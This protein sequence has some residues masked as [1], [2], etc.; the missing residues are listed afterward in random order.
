MNKSANELR[1]MFFEVKEKNGKIITESLLHTDY[2][3][4]LPK[5]IHLA[6][7]LSHFLRKQDEEFSTITD[8]SNSKEILKK[9]QDKI[10]ES[11][12]LFDGKKFLNFVE[13]DYD[14]E[15]LIHRERFLKGENLDMNVS[16]PFI[17]N[18][19]SKLNR[20]IEEHKSLHEDL[21]DIDA[22]DCAEKFLEYLKKFKPLERNLYPEIFFNDIAYSIFV[23]MRNRFDKNNYSLNDFYSFLFKYLK[24]N[25]YLVSKKRNVFKNYLDESLNVDFEFK[26][27]SKYSEKYYSLLNQVLANYGLMY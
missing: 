23:D 10:N 2:K 15:K 24:E 6:F 22:I 7:K 13:T 17:V 9:Y 5:E 19:I 27:R 3:K 11:V 1:K 26:M 12:K 18:L 20:K 21:H 16:Q 25:E 8:D 14:Y 4:D